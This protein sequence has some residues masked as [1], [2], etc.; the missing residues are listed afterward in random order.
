MASEC[1]CVAP[2]ASLPRLAILLS[3]LASATSAPAT[4]DPPTAKISSRRRDLYSSGHATSCA[5]A[6]EG[7]EIVFDC[8]GELISAVDFGSFGTPGGS[9]ESNDFYRDDSC[10]ARQ[11]VSALEDRCLGQA[12]CLFTVTASVFGGAPSCGGGDSKKLKLAAVLAC[13]ETGGA[14]AKAAS[15]G[16]LG[17]GWQF[18][19]FVLMVFLVY[20]GLGIAYN[21]QR[22]GA[23]GVEALPHLEMWKDLPFLV[24]DGVVFAVDTIKSKG[25]PGYDGL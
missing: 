8:G 16:G 19:L 7:D 5:V 2:S 21:V 18:N 3:L 17:I 12:T 6:N 23:K 14:N 15:S 11:T 24:R 10:H 20:C 25:R 1:S 13:G 9:C 22:K 4:S